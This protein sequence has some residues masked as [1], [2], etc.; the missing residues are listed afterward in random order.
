MCQESPC[1]HAG[2]YVKNV[3]QYYTVRNEESNNSEAISFNQIIHPYAIVTTQ[4]CDLDWDYRA[5]QGVADRLKLLNSVI[6]CGIST[7]TNVRSIEDKGTMN[8]GEWNLVKTQ[9]H[10]RFYFFEKIPIECDLEQ[11]GLPEL[12]V[13]FK[14]VFG[15]HA[16]DLYR[17]VDAEMVKRRSTL[18]SPY[19]EHFSRRYSAFHSRVALPSQYES[20][21][22][23]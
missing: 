1:V 5:R 16:E 17:Q 7:A 3:V 8:S 20:E 18:T 9:R 15:I 4:D 19:L 23:G 6:L 12:T 11:E 2:E 13:D 14:K 21:R 22:E 10:E